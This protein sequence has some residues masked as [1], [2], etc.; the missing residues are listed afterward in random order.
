MAEVIGVT[1][2]INREIYYFK[3]NKIKVNK[4]SFVVVKN[5]QGLFLGTVV[6]DKINDDKIIDK[7]E[8]LATKKDFQTKEKNIKDAYKALIKC[9]SIAQK[10]NLN[11]KII[12]SFYTLD[13]DKL[14]FRFTSPER[15]DFRVLAKE[16][17]KIYKVRIELRQIGIRDEASIVGG[18]GPCG[19]VLCCVRFLKDLNAVSINMAKNQNISLN[20]TKINGLCG[21]LMCCLKYENEGYCK[22]RLTMKQIGHEI[23]TSKGKGTIVGLDI[24]N[25]KYK[26]S[27]PD[28]GII[29]VDKNESN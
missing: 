27:I 26:V 19:Q 17:A 10:N 3:T 9:R 28:S 22:C 23:D 16:L 15:I 14:V 2:P 12:D 8:R 20:P 6:T 24:L 13:R 11:M 21:R 5:D 18:L 4:G 1:I 29:E 7:I 25:Q